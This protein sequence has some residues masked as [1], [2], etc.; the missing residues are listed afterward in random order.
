MAAVASVAPPARAPAHRPGLLL[1]PG[2]PRVVLVPLHPLIVHLQGQARCRAELVEE[3][4]L[5]VAGRQA[6]R[7]PGHGKWQQLQAAAREQTLT[8]QLVELAVGY[9]YVVLLCVFAVQK[10]WACEIHKKTKGGCT[11]SSAARQRPLLSPA[12]LALACFQAAHA[13]QSRISALQMA[14]VSV[15]PQ[16][17]PRSPMPTAQHAAGE[18]RQRVRRAHPRPR[19]CCPHGATL[20]R[21]TKTSPSLTHKLHVREAEAAGRLLNLV[22]LRGRCVGG[23]RQGLEQGRRFAPAPCECRSNACQPPHALRPLLSA[24]AHLVVADALLAPA[25]AVGSALHAAARDEHFILVKEES[26]A[27]A[28]WRAAL[29]EGVGGGTGR[30]VDWWSGGGQGRAERQVEAGSMAWPRSPSVELTRWAAA[31]WRWA[32]RRHPGP[33]G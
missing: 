30:P 12:P 7:E 27:D 20:R 26:E 21:T 15:G 14:P 16:M 17:W 1:L 13:C 23:R 8:C 4:W 11:Q 29:H 25:A 3:C 28:V 32:R 6:G 18:V 5:A 31:P 10:V 22:E 33:P 24:P 9:E 2:G 19:C